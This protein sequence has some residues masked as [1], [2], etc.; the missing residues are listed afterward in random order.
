MVPLLDDGPV[1][2]SMLDS[3]KLVDD[4]VSVSLSVLDS[5]V[6]VGYVGIGVVRL[7]LKYVELLLEPMLEVMFGREY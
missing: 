6:V 7:G 2:A 5:S 4:G 1:G 3:G